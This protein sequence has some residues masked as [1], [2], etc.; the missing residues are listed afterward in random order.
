MIKNAAGTASLGSLCRLSDRNAQI[1]SLDSSP[2]HPDRRLELRE[3][4]GTER[5]LG[6]RP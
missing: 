5:G 2:K 6:T 1:E 4:Q 3:F